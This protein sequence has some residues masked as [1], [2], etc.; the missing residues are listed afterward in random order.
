MEGS[1]PFLF[2]PDCWRENKSHESLKQRAS[3]GFCI[4]GLIWSG[5]FVAF[6]ERRQM[7]FEF[8]PDSTTVCRC[9]FFFFDWFKNIFITSQRN[10]L[11]GKIKQSFFVRTRSLCST[12][13]KLRI[14]IKKSAVV[15][16]SHINPLVSQRRISH[17]LPIPLH[18]LVCDISLHF[19]HAVPRWS[20]CAYMCVCVCVGPLGFSSF[21]STAF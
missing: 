15:L 2:P 17:D 8:T 12:P 13:N 20:V 3:E 6:Y 4:D 1:A 14:I 19:F 18:L 5:A 16:T 10:H 7:S 9:R 11:R 21:N